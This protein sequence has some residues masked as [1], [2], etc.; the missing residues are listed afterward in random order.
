[1][2]ES[3]LARQSQ[4]SADRQMDEHARDGNTHTYTPRIALKTFPSLEINPQA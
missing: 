4:K 2:D 1:M 3:Q